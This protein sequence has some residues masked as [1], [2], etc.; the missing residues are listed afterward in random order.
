M[1][2][3][4]KKTGVAAPLPFSCK[5][6]CFQ[7]WCSFGG[8]R[9]GSI[10]WNSAMAAIFWEIWEERNRYFSRKFREIWDNFGI[11]LSPLLLYRFPYLKSC[12]Y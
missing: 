3:T 7:Y 5:S 1:D 4:T 12:G 8:R 2:E 9:K 6:L 10:L 11:G